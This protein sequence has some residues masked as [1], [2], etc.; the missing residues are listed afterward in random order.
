[1]TAA[2]S[3]FPGM[4]GA[5]RCTPESGR[6]TPAG[7][8]REWHFARLQFGW[9]VERGPRGSVLWLILLEAPPP[10]MSRVLPRSFTATFLLPA[11]TDRAAPAEG[12]E[13]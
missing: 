4:T 1:M 10:R 3:I 7:E 5:R 2:A 11:T 12:G 13:R 9:R 8:E 6:T